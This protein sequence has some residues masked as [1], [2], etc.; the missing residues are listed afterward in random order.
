MIELY[1]L[2][3][4][5]YVEKVRWA[6][7]FKQLPWRGIEVVAFIK[8]ELQRF[9]CAQTFPLIHDT[10]TGVAI[11][12][13]SPIIR[14]LEDTYPAHPLF[15][16]DPA[17]REEA[18]QWM[19]RLDSTLGLHGRRLG[20]TQ[21]IMECPD[22]L[23]QLFMA[24]VAGGVFT[25]RGLRR[26]ASAVLGAMLTL[27]FRFH[28]NRSDRVY[29]KLEAQLL[30]IA[31]KIEREGYLVGRAFSAADITLASLLRP[32]RIVPHFSH[33]PRLQSMF[34]WQER[35][36]REHGRDAAY[37]YEEAIRAR[38]ERSGWMRGH[39]RWMRPTLEGLD[40]HTQ[41]APLQVARNDIHPLSRWM[42]PLGLPAY[43]KLRWFNGIGRMRY[44]PAAFIAGA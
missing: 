40:V 22:T 36:F 38:R 11:S 14:Y 28:R 21:V 1:K 15:P 29:E 4:S 24:N 43:L 19:L 30:P 20:Y 33:H 12:D 25:R 17:R 35:L 32:L 2:H 16:A 8:K 9:D 10:A 34:A 31:A 39:V 26:P 5:H 42:L 18:W 41:A 3:W 6:L 27:R 44:T 7:D 13:S 23:A 37:P